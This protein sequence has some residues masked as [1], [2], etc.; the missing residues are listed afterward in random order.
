MRQSRWLM[1]IAP[2]GDE[3]IYSVTSNFGRNGN[4]WRE[5]HGA[6]KVVRDKTAKLLTVHIVDKGKPLYDAPLSK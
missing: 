5:A 4:A 2:N 6:F 3:T 1:S